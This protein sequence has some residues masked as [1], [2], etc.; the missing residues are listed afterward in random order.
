MQVTSCYG[1][2]F[3]LLR[4]FLLIGVGMT[5]IVAIGKL[6]VFTF[7]VPESW[8]DRK[9]FCFHGAGRAGVRC[10]SRRGRRNALEKCLR[11]NVYARTSSKHGNYDLRHAPRSHPRPGGATSLVTPRRERTAIPLLGWLCNGFDHETTTFS[12]TCFCPCQT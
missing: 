3:T 10:R 6:A 1:N 2:V 11:A 8:H 5:A 7:E 4:Q 9:P 12:S